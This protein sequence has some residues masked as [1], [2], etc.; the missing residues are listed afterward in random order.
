M[1]EE[2]IAAN[3]GAD[4]TNGYLKTLSYKTAFQESYA[5]LS[6]EEHASQTAMLKALP[7]FDA[8][9]FFEISGI[10]IT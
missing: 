4:V 6:E 3:P 8:D 2:E 9:V 1:T 7:N 5:A 10:R